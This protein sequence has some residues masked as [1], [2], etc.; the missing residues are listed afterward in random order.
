[1]PLPNV[2]FLLNLQVK[3]FLIQ[4]QL[5]ILYGMLVIMALKAIYV[6]EQFVCSFVRIACQSGCAYSRIGY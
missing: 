2:D 6:Y 4:F 3:E 5:R 1:M